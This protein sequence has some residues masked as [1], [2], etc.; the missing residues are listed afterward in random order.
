MKVSEI[1]KRYLYLSDIFTVNDEYSKIDSDGQ[2]LILYPDKLITEVFNLIS[3]IPSRDRF[4]TR[5]ELGDRLGNYINSITY[6]IGIDG[7]D[8]YSIFKLIEKLGWFKIAIRME[9][10][11]STKV[12]NEQDDKK[13]RNIIL[14]PKD[15][16]EKALVYSFVYRIIEHKQYPEHEWTEDLL[17][18]KIPHSQ[19]KLSRDQT[20]ENRE[21]EERYSRSIRKSLNP[22]L[23]ASNRLNHYYFRKLYYETPDS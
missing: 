11:N 16:R 15:F 10:Y 2:N 6:N 19:D 12:E 18:Y 5:L 22:D 1:A 4:R 14:I 17:D 20:R 7:K 13:V 3:K 8:Y 23:Q 9:K 21:F